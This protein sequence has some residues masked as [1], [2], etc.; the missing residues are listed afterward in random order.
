[1]A[2][3][4]RREVVNVPLEDFYRAVT[5]YAA[6]PQF[7]T[8]AKSVRVLSETPEAK[9]VEFD[10]EM[11]KKV[12]YVINV[13]EQIDRTAGT[14]TVNWTLDRSDMFKSNT[15]GWTMRAIDPTHTEVVYKLDVDFAFSVPGFIL[16]GLVANSLPTAIREFAERAAKLGKK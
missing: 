10:V 5:D 2:G 1:M 15:G 13:R 6:Y 14:A 4:D 11:M 7:V 12:N 16:K 9:K 3:A 8:G